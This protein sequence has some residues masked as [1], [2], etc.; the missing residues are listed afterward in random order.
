MMPLRQLPTFSELVIS[1]VTNGGQRKP[2]IADPEALY[3]AIMANQFLAVCGSL[4]YTF[5]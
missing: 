4:F 5:W 2:R 1:S 3:Q